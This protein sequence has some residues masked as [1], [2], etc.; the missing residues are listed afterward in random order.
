MYVAATRLF[1]VLPV[2]GVRATVVSS[3]LISVDVTVVGSVGVPVGKY[4]VIS[5]TNCCGVSVTVV[6][7]LVVVV[8]QVPRLAMLILLSECK[9]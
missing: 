2:L 4:D 8:G 1:K 6:T 3:S 7:I 9:N 5:V